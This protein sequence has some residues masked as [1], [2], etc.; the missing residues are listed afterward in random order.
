V[1]GK[2]KKFV[3]DLALVEQNYVKDE[4][5]KVKNL[6]GEAKIK[7]FARYAVGNQ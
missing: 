3:A 7:A 2:I 5:K 6:M 4:K 1:E